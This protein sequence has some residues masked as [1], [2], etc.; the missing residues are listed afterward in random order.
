M[1]QLQ[2]ENNKEGIRGKFPQMAEDTLLS[3]R[4]SCDITETVVSCCGY[5][6]TIVSALWPDNSS[7]GP[8]PET[9]NTRGLAPD[10][11]LPTDL[12]ALYRGPPPSS[13]YTI[14]EVLVA[15]TTLPPGPALTTGSG[16]PCS[17]SRALQFG[18]PVWPSSGPAVRPGLRSNCLLWP[19][20]Q[21]P[22]PTQ[23][24]GPHNQLATQP[25]TRPDIS[26]PHNTK[27]GK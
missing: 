26:R 27:T 3:L 6:E 18:P 16:G 2:R 12:S 23:T 13:R 8:F 9:G 22:G 14:L 11:R 15:P 24:P 7:Y 5:S 19:A 17:C 20:V 21:R 10:S 1:A 4:D 25:P